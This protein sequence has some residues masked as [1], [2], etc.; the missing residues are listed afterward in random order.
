MADSFSLAFEQVQLLSGLPA[1]QAVWLYM[2]ASLHEADTPDIVLDVKEVGALP[3]DANQPFPPELPI[4]DQGKFSASLPIGAI[5]RNDRTEPST[6]Q[7]FPRF[8]L[9]A[10]TVEPSQAITLEVFLVPKVWFRTISIPRSELDKWS[11]TAFGA[12]IG[13]SGFGIPGAIAGTILGILLGEDDQDVTVPCSQTVVSARHVFPFDDLVAL[14]SEGMRQYGPADNWSS[15]C[16]VID[17]LYWLS[18]DFHRPWTFA[19]LPSP[20]AGDCELRPHRHMPIAEWVDG[21]W[22]DRSRWETSRVGV[23]ISV[24]NDTTA[25]VQVFDDPDEPNRHGRQF[26]TCPITQDIPPLDVTLNYYGGGE[27]PRSVSPTCPNCRRFTN[28]LTYQQID[29]KMIGALVLGPTHAGAEKWGDGL[30]GP[31]YSTSSVRERSGARRASRDTGETTRAVGK[32]AFR[33][34]EDGAIQFWAKG[35]SPP[36]RPTP[37]RARRYIDFDESVKTTFPDVVTSLFG[38]FKIALGDLEALYTYAEY[39]ANGEPDCPRIRYIRWTEDGLI[40]RDAILQLWV[41]PPA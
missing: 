39:P 29:K 20:E 2:R 4:G 37:S 35:T 11:E 10:M 13:A 5:I 33:E 40:E 7:V 31:G 14:R 34:T 8:E 12:L 36:P 17:S 32:L 21:V 15:V 30:V 1:D 9:P 24:T 19:P 27:P 26:N 18:S 23:A 41:K 6:S 3:P 28:V 22:L 38:C 25:D 16:G